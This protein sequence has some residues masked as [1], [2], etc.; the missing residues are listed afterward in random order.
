MEASKIALVGPSH[1]YRGGIAHFQ[2]TMH[3][4]LAARGHVVDAVTFSR[5]YPELLFPG[6]TQ[7]VEAAPPDPLPS[8]RMLDTINPLSWYRTARHLVEGA[9]DVV[10]YQYWMPFFAPAYGSIARYTRRRGLRSLAVVH[11]ALPHE[12]M[13]GEALLSRYFLQ[14]CSG[15]IVMSESVEEDLRELAVQGAA[16]RVAHPTYDLFGEAKP[17]A[18]A[19]RMLNLPVEAPVLLFFGFVR[20][21][22]GLRVLLDALPAVVSEVPDVQLVVAGAFYDDE[23]SYRALIQEHGLEDHVRLDAGYVP[24]ERVPQYFSAADVVVQPYVSATQSGVAQIAFHFDTPVITTDVG[25][26]AETVPHERAGLVVPPEDPR[27]LARAITRFFQE[28]MASELAAGAREAKRSYSW[29]RLYE[30]IEDLASR[31]ERGRVRHAPKKEEGRRH[32]EV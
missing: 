21:Y 4:G 20:P 19:R 14:A 29:D 3:R 15:Y 11:N 6:R 28:D 23:T 27:A 22:K 5:Q 32:P 12:H 13:V 16:R 31:P 26:L 24:D 8:I 7:Y 9:P 25:G 30:A 1:P 17:K 2:E 18:A 10:V